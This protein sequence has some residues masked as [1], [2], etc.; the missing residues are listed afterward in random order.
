[1]CP[2]CRETLQGA[3]CYCPDHYEF[4]TDHS[5]CVDINECKY[6]EYCDQLCEN[7]DGSY[8]CNCEEGYSNNGTKGRCLANNRDTARIIFANY[9]NIQLYSL[10]GRNLV[11]PHLV[12]GSQIETLDFDIKNNSVCWVNFVKS[13]ESNLKCVSL[14]DPSHTWQIHTHHKLTSVSHVARD[15]VGD[16]WYFA[17]DVKETI[18]LCSGNGVH[19][20]NIINIDIKRP[21]SLALDPTRG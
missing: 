2:M 4:D 15:W 17:D 18:F 7:H 10:N 16:N 11:E 12:N 19:C 8:E 9:N 13:T 6:N 20:V 3:H 21:K 5:I 14:L 1:K